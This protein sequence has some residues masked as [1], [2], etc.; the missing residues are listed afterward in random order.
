MQ[1]N[2]TAAV[3]ATIFRPP[4]S[5]I[6]CGLDLTVSATRGLTACRKPHPRS[7][8]LASDGQRAG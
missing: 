3:K 4:A 2:S 8:R 1:V 7:G 5:K 6:R